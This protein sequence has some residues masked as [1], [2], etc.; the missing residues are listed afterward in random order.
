MARNGTS[1]C[2]IILVGWECAV[3]ISGNMDRVVASFSSELHMKSPHI[4]WQVR[5]F[6]RG[7]NV[8]DDLALCWFIYKYFG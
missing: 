8:F 4:A 5:R 1:G 6:K 2:W 7:A 3:I